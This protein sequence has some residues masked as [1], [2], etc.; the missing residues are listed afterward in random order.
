M[1]LAST[2]YFY[3]STNSTLDGFAA[4][5]LEAVLP[6][7][8]ADRILVTQDDAP[9]LIISASIPPTVTVHDAGTG[10]LVRDVA[11]VG[12]ASSLLYAP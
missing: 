4:W 7:T 8:G 12:I 5:L 2:T 9:V 1:P 6:H 10:V 3:L 11:E